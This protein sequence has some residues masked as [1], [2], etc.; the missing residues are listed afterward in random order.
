[1]AHRPQALA[2]CWAWSRRT[3]GGSGGQCSAVHWATSI[4][5]R[6]KP[7]EDAGSA[8][9]GLHGRSRHAD[10]HGCGAMHQLES[11]HQR[12]SDPKRDAA[13]PLGSAA[14]PPSASP[15]SASPT[16]ASPTSASPTSA[17]SDR[18][19]SSDLQGSAQSIR[20][21]STTDLR[22]TIVEQKLNRC[23]Q[24]AFMAC[25]GRKPQGHE[26][27][28]ASAGAAVLFALFAH[29]AEG[30]D[31]LWWSGTGA[32]GSR[33]RPGGCWAGGWPMGRR[34]TTRAARR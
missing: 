11:P 12:L 15:T 29:I 33:G 24:I 18:G 4:I 6:W 19:V 28:G 30:C 9:V 1:M 31:D 22:L 16:A 3:G 25:V 13:P 7:M 14:P 23:L 34:Q 27:F 8:L 17:V 5:A 20:R 26:R 10:R 32:P 2:P 21:Q